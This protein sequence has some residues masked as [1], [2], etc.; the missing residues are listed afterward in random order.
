MKR[1]VLGPVGAVVLAAAVF[2]MLLS[3]G[4]PEKPE[5]KPADDPKQP[6]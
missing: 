4:C 6:E 1:Y 2:A 5:D 3:G